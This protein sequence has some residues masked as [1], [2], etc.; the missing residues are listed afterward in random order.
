MAPS[1][2][3]LFA[4]T[5]AGKAEELA[6]YL[7]ERSIELRILADLDD[8]PAVTEDRD[9]LRGNARKKAEVLFERVGVPTVADDTGL[10]V[11][12]LDGAPGVRSARFAGT[13]VSDA[14]NRRHLLERLEG[15]DDRSA[16]FR[17]VLAYVT[18]NGIRYFEGVCEGTILR[19]G[20]GTGGFGYDRLFRPSGHEE[21]F[22]EMSTEQKNR[23]SH[24]GRALR[25]F[26]RAI[27]AGVDASTNDTETDLSHS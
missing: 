21:T 25:S 13:N 10:E 1:R 24:R 6:A 7:D 8:P 17:T 18:G 2:P 22:A 23:I 15:I 16:R 4:T 20:R 14:E 11:D 12:A 26:A 27:D 9:T 19:E 5:N 3:L